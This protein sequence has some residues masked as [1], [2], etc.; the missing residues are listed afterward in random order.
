MPIV[1]H[2]AAVVE[3]CG[4][5]IAAVDETVAAVIGCASSGAADGTTCVRNQLYL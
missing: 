5:I 2:E 3:C 1:P 4:C